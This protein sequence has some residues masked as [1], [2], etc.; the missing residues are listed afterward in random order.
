MLKN[1]KSF[2]GTAFLMQ[3]YRTYIRKYLY[4]TNVLCYSCETIKTNWRL[5]KGVKHE[6][7]FE[8]IRNFYYIPTAVFIIWNLVHPSGDSCHK[9]WTYL[10][11]LILLI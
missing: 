8:N 4:K 10:D 2:F 5:D 11:F 9:L 1:Q 6:N 3:F 7:K